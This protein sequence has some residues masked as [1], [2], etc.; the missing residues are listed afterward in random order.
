MKIYYR[1][2]FD[3][4]G[5]KPTQPDHLQMLALNDYVKYCLGKNKKDI[6]FAEL[7][8][9]GISADKIKYLVESGY[10]KTKNFINA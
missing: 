10:F 2:G 8:N 9:V 5:I 6:T 3:L 4:T 1:G 7:C